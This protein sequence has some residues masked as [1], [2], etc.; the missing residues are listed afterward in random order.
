MRRLWRRFFLR[1]GKILKKCKEN[2]IHTA[3]DTAGHIPRE[4]FEK[5]LPF[6]DLF[7]Y[8]IKAM[9]EE[10]HKEYT[11]VTNTRILENLKKLLKSDVDVW[12]RV[13]VISAVND[14]ED[15]MQKIKSFFDINGYP[16][17]AELLPY[18]AMGE[19]KYEALGKSAEKFEV[20]NK[21][22]MEKL[23]KIVVPH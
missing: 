21:E 3:V 1:L 20:P 18:H 12:V 4:S 5:I 22:K 6:T 16:E 7:L 15:E 8:D 13:P 14:T 19:H 9:N 17:K 2:G 11:G 10:I 23:R